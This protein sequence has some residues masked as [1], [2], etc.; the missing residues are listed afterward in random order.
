MKSI[1]KI[2]LALTV[3]FSACG[4]NKKASKPEEAQKGT[5]T[6][7][8]F[9]AETIDGKKL[10]FASLKGKKV[11]I[12]NT[13]SKCGFTYQYEGLQKLHKAHGDKLVIL[14][15]PSNNFGAQEPGSNTEIAEFCQKNYG[16]DFQM[17][18]KIDVKGDNAHPLFKWLSDKNQ[19]GWNNE[20]P[21]W[22]FTKFLVNEKG[23]LVKVYG[24]KIKPMSD[25]ILQAI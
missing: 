16:V 21:S 3:L 25:E 20:G 7:H 4:L 23:E 9:S 13:A 19:N 14:G 12:V 8:D 2:L 15:F 24:S 6:F 1:T 17:F 11:L 10:E 22:N 18:A 5:K